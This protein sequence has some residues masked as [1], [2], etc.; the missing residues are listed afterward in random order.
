MV[1]KFET[2]LVVPVSSE[3]GDDN[4]L[5]SGGFDEID[6]VDICVSNKL[7]SEQEERELRAERNIGAR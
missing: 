5:L 3:E 2:P 7:L 1:S 6:I 4:F